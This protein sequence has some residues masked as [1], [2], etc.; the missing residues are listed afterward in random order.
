MST[1]TITATIPRICLRREEAAAALGV[2]EESFDRHV[3]HEVRAIRRG[4][5]TLYP[6]ADLERW[7][8]DSA[9]ATLADE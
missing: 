9:A 4:R 2:S 6:I 5:L 8:R 1:P 7:A 3:R